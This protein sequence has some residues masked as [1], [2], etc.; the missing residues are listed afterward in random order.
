MGKER[1]TPGDETS[2]TVTSNNSQGSGAASS[3]GKFEA[4][5]VCTYMSAWT[6]S[7]VLSFPYILSIPGLQLWGQL[8][9]KVNHEAMIQYIYISH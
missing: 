1:E 2:Q 8:A 4:V 5:A 9:N 6:G 3:V 7:Q